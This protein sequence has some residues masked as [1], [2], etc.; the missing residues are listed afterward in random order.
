MFLPDS[1]SRLTAP[2]S[3]KSE[4]ASAARFASG[5]SVAPSSENFEIVVPKL[6][7]I[8][9]GETANAFGPPGSEIGASHAPVARS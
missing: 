3:A 2:F 1:W 5:V 9:C 4:R 6:T 8:S 7:K